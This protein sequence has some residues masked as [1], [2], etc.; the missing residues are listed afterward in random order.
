MAPITVSTHNNMEVIGAKAIDYLRN[1]VELPDS[2]KG[3]M[4]VEG[5]I[6]Y[7]FPQE[8]VNAPV[9][10]V[11]QFKSGFGSS[12]LE[13]FNTAKPVQNIMALLIYVTGRVPDKLC[14]PNCQKVFAR[15]IVPSHFG[16]GPLLLHRK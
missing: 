1:V 11:L 2:I 7:R 10:R 16:Y 3:F 12:N 8:L 5:E 4:A 15:C 14:R 13:A 9:K 6:Q